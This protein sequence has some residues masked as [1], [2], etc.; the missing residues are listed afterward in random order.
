MIKPQI[1]L[2]LTSTI[3]FNEYYIHVINDFSLKNQNHQIDTYK[4]PIGKTQVES[5]KIIDPKTFWI[6]SEDESNSS[7]ARLMKVKL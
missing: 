4:I 1:P 5:I 7:S 3:S 6:S 2:A